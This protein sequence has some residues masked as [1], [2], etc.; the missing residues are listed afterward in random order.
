MISSLAS[1]KDFIRRNSGG[2]EKLR[3]EE[4]DLPT[5][6][7]SE[8]LLKRKRIKVA[9][10]AIL[11]GLVSAAIDLPLPAEDGFRAVRA[12]L[13]TRPAPQDIVMVT[14]DD[15]TLNEMGK[16]LPSRF[17]DSDLIDRLVASGVEKI[18]F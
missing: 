15:A 10:F 14:V 5:L 8:S 3:A 1:L 11:F 6:N 13:R 12:Q 18:V 4:S 2:A 16:P 7:S 9:I 17:D